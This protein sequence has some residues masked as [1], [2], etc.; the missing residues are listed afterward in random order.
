MTQFA[1]L[2]EKITERVFILKFKDAHGIAYQR[3]WYEEKL[4]GV[5]LAPVEC[6]Q[7]L[8]QEMLVQVCKRTSTVILILDLTT[9]QGQ[10][11]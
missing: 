4:T 7:P 6:V 10:E 8:L 1:K 9:N 3:R 2:V 11:I 5:S